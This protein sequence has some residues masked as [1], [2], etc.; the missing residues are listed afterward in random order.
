MVKRFNRLILLII[1]YGLLT[2]NVF[3]VKTYDSYNNPD[4]FEDFT[5]TNLINVYT[6]RYLIFTNT[7]FDL[8]EGKNY[9]LDS[10]TYLYYNIF[11]NNNIEKQ[12]VFVTIYRNPNNNISYA[13]GNFINISGND[14]AEVIV[15]PDYNM[16]YI[17]TE[18]YCNDNLSST[19]GAG[20]QVTKQ[21]LVAP[22][23]Q[24]Y[25]TQT[26]FVPLINSV[27]DLIK[28]NLA[29]W[30]ILFYLLILIII[31]VIIYGLFRLAFYILNKTKQLENEYK[32]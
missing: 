10:K 26:I 17:A 7:S 4:Y 23:Y 1:F 11:N 32:N 18:I 21:L 12:F 31:S 25:K 3:A 15:E 19:C 22:S 24:D 5:D 6:F 8:D 14:Y 28:I 29:I 20:Y 27:I 9:I 13:Y 16:E 30:R 2:L